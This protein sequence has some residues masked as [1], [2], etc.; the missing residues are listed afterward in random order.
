MATFPLS[1]STLGDEEAFGARQ[2]LAPSER[3]ED[4]LL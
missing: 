3:L 2:S 1:R 4:V